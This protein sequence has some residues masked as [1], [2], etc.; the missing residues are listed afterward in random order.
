[1]GILSTLLM[2]PLTAPAKGTLWLASK[3]AEAAE[4]D[5]ND[6]RQL[7]AALRAAEAELLAGTMS[8][9]EYDEIETDILLRLRGASG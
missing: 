6:P 5:F 4:A 1:M 8:E 3:I 7:R 2:A 9:D